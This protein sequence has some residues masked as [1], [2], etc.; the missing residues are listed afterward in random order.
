MPP[1][2]PP[3][4]MQASSRGRDAPSLN[5]TGK[6][7]RD[8]PARLRNSLMFIQLHGAKPRPPCSHEA[9]H[10]P[11]LTAQSSVCLGC[12]SALTPQ[13]HIKPCPQKQ[14]R[15]HLEITTNFPYQRSWCWQ[16]QS[17]SSYAGFDIF[18]HS[19][20]LYGPL[21]YFK[22]NSDPSDSTKQHAWML[23]VM[24]KVPAT[25]LSTAPLWQN[26]CSGLSLEGCY[27]PCCVGKEL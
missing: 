21:K 1:R 4:G 22:G 8:G 2:D 19:L 17:W 20:H 9:L 14:S 16:L 11:G 23:T 6:E 12:D 5:V 3:S 7:G 15:R 25:Q 26:T 13:P 10:G 27:Q 24:P 18:K